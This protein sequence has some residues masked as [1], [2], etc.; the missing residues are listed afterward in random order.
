MKQTDIMEIALLS[1]LVI[2]NGVILY[3]I[4]RRR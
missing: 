2:C 4:V 3:N 1:I